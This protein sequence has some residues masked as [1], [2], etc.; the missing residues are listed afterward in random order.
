MIDVLHRREQQREQPDPAHRLPAGPLQLVVELGVLELLQV[1]RRRVA[2]ELDAGLVG[3]E[4]AEQALEQRGEAR[5]ALAHQRDGELEREQLAQPGPVD[6]RHAP[7]RRQPDRAHH[8]V[9]DQ[10][11]DPQH[12]E[13]NERAR[14]PERQDA[15]D[16]PRLGAPHQPQQPRHV[17][18]RLE[19]RAP[20]RTGRRGLPAPAV[21]PYYRVP[22]WQ[23]HVQEANRAES[24]RCPTSTGPRSGPTSRTSARSTTRH[25]PRLARWRRWFG[26]CWSTCCWCCALR[27]V[28]KRVLAQLNPFDFVVLLM[29]SN[30]VQNAIIGNDTSLLG[31]VIGAAAL[32]GVNAVLVRIYY[33][34][35]EMDAD[36]HR[37]AR[38]LPDRGRPPP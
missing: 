17:T 10:L 3:E 22:E 26:R 12:R 5:Q 31:G 15:R 37:R 36:V 28:G 19:A 29:L 18:E 8:L 38:H 14:H 27:T 6:A 1:E 13:R 34:G 23:C 35:P 32:L 20:A 7:A 2:H 25:A 9:H 21:G 33:R 11:A 4:I 16:V 30:T 24:L